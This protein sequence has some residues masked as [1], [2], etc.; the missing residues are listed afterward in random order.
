[1]RYD[2]SKLDRVP[3][4]ERLIYEAHQEPE[5]EDLAWW[6]VVSFEG[7]MHLMRHRQRQFEGKTVGTPRPVISIAARCIVLSE[8]LNKELHHDGCWIVMLTSRDP[9]NV[10]LLNA[11]SDYR[12]CRVLWADKDGDVQ[13]VMHLDDF[14]QP[15]AL[16]NDVD[17]YTDA[18][19][20]AFQKYL[21]AIHGWID[22]QPDQVLTH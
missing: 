9:F 14:M 4:L 5:T 21:E 13:F 16:A 10:L 12:Q 8:H 17:V 19:E 20:E 11:Q 2:L 7:P 22:V 1:M 15:A 6:A 18:C 3:F